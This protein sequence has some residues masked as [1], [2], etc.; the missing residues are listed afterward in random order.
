MF[1]FC[2]FFFNWKCGWSLTEDEDAFD[3]FKT[4]SA[5]HV[6]PLQEAGEPLLTAQAGSFNA[7]QQ[8]PQLDGWNHRAH[9]H[10]HRHRGPVCQPFHQHTEEGRQLK[11]KSDLRLFV[12]PRFKMTEMTQVSWR[13]PSFSPPALFSLSVLL[14]YA[15]ETVPLEFVATLSC[16]LDNNAG[17]SAAC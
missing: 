1:F 12:F 8:W 16:T 11:L 7:S 2:L 10:H 4:R 14:F 3:A 17:T 13:A 5:A 9:P 6:G 15:G